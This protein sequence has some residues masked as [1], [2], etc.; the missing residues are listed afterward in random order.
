[1]RL[2]DVA[3][4]IAVRCSGL[5]DSE[6]ARAF[7]S[8]CR[9]CGIVDGP[10]LQ[11]AFDSWRRAW[12]KR[13]PPTAAEFAAHYERPRLA[14]GEAPG[15]TKTRLPDGREWAK[16][17]MLLPEGQDALTRGCGYDLWLWARQNPG[18]VPPRDWVE[19]PAA[20]AARNAAL[21]A[22]GDSLGEM[23]RT[24]RSA[25]A[26]MQH[27]E[28]VLRAKFLRATPPPPERETAELTMR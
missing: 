26:A 10:A 7:V 23:D 27:R 4:E 1:M 9:A 3:A 15:E 6:R 14:T 16:I 25:W 2:S 12:A 24:L 8:D 11:T 20:A 19:A 22:S 5:S 21:M 17:V 18:L 28:S 13:F